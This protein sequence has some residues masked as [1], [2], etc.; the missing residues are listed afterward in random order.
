MATRAY[1]VVLTPRAQILSDSY[2]TFFADRVKVE[3]N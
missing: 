2:I 3:E 1:A